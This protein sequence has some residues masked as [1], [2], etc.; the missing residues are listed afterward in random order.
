VLAACLVAGCQQRAA[1]K[2]AAAGSPATEQRFAFKGKIIKVD[3]EAKQAEIAHDEIPGYMAAMTMVYP[4][5]DEKALA[6]LGPGAEITATL[7]TRPGGVY[8]LQ[9]V[10]IANPA[11]KP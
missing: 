10:V 6:E 5:R 11:A 9:D 8:F 7:V 4:I 2:P 1:S 3:R